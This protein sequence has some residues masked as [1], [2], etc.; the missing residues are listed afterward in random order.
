M[1]APSRYM[2]TATI[3]PAP[4]SASGASWHSVSPA[5]PLHPKISPCR[6][7]PIY[8]RCSCRSNSNPYT[9]THIPSH[10][11]RTSEYNRPPHVG[12]GIRSGIRSPQA[13]MPRTRRSKAARPL[14][15]SI[16]SC[17]AVPVTV[18]LQCSLLL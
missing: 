3:S 18:A 10:S 11:P 5:Y 9:S 14:P 1:R 7:H 2:F 8:R 6:A 12:Y 4:S 15:I 16:L 13:H 17:A